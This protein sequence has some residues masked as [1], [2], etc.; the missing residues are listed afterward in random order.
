VFSHRRSQSTL[1][2]WLQTQ[3]TLGESYRVRI[4]GSKK[5]NVEHAIRHLQQ[6]LETITYQ[7]DPENW[8]Q[9]QNSLG[10]AYLDRILGNRAENIQAAIDHYQQALLVRTPES[11]PENWAMTE[12]NL[13]NAYRF[14]IRGSQA[15]NIEEAIRHFKLALE[16]RTRSGYPEDWAQTRDNLGNAYLAR[17]HE[18][19]AENIEKAIDNYQQALDMRA[20]LALPAGWAET[21]NNLGNAYLVRVKGQQAENLEQAVEH[22]EQA[23]Q[24]RTRGAYPEEWA[25]T[26][27]NLAGAERLRGP[28]GVKKAIAHLTQALEVRTR[29][30]FPEAWAETHNNLA[31]SY[32]DLAEGDQAQNVE[33]ALLHYQQA[34]EVYTIQDFPDH[35]LKTARSLGNLAFE[36]RRWEL[37]RDSYNT[38]FDALDLLMQTSF[39]REVKQIELGEVQNLSPRGAYA[40]VECGNVKQAV[41]VLE[42]GRAQLLRESLE[43]RR[44][45]LEH[46]PA[47]GYGAQYENY[48]QA[49]REYDEL[50]REGTS[51]TPHAED[52]ISRIDQTLSWM[53]T[54]AAAIREE[55][56][57]THP[58]YRYFMQ[59]LPFSEIQKQAAETPLV[60]LTATSAGGLA[61]IVGPKGV[62][63]IKLPDL[64]QNT[65]Q[66]QIWRPSD[67]EIDRIN[68]H[69]KQG[70]ITQ[71]DIESVKGGYFSMYALWS[72]LMGTSVQETLFKAWQQTLDDT[73]RWLWNAFMGDLADRLRPFVSSAVLIP[74]GYL[75]LLPLHAAWIEDM[76]QSTRRRYVLDEMNFTYA[77]SAH[78]LWQSGLAAGRPA[79]SLLAVDNPEAEVQ[80]RS[81]AFS[82]DEVEAVLS[83]FEKSNRRH[84]PGRAA[85]LEEVKRH[86]QTTHVL[87]FSCHANAGWDKEDEA[88][89]VLADGDLKLPDLFDLDLRQAR[90]A[91]LSACETGV[92]SLK[93]IDEVIGLPAG[94]MQAGVPGVVGSLWPVSDQSTSMLMAR[95]YR[96]WRTEGCSPQEAL[97]QAQIWLRDSTTVQKKKFFSTLMDDTA[98][99]MSAEIAEVFYEY[100]AW[101]KSEARTF[102]SPYYWAAFTYTGL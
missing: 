8:G 50:Q 22:Y 29:Q 43:R 56:G 9:T 59:A 94:M 98:A 78:A 41:E 102:A 65:L 2:Y 66:K 20:S 48:I 15:E 100:I 87:H 12:Y 19:R 5:R 69:L 44:Q 83:G 10:N 35:C 28:E 36:D 55:A 82:G 80:G 25:Q 23:L 81:L 52:W 60:Y 27:S 54:A 17:V 77:P 67:E 72:L 7:S 14:R 49:M 85:N 93:L 96:L 95:F 45:D 58:Q 24:A 88:R 62:Q 1:L 92:P 89:L 86:M 37:A 39:L 42:R 51:H 75:A 46:L 26:L 90:L 57:R 70:T 6:A 63:A 4:H 84:L 47:L 61:L 73:T 74:S 3:N 68:G 33:Q 18:D 13:G 11:D 76:T 31:I 91:V 99:G 38:A 40:N 101:K 16:V 64:H 79:E 71:E 21:Q 97:R 30:A 32:K 53:Q 34:L